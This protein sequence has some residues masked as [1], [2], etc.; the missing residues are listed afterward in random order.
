MIEEEIINDAI[1][2]SMLSE[3]PDKKVGCIFISNLS[4]GTKF[5]LSSGYNHVPHE[6]GLSCK[7]ENGKTRPELIHAEAHALRGLLNKDLSN[8]DLELYT[9]LSPCIECAKLAFLCG[10]K[11]I[12]YRDLYKDISGLK[13]LNK[14]GIET[15]QLI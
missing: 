10:I 5:R 7:D 3:D 11:R 6:L 13:F 1:K 8:N 15:K 9:T 4:N 14:L 2:V 12:Y